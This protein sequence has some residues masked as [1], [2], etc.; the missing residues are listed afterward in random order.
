MELATA[1]VLTVAAGLVVF[2]VATAVVAG[3][4]LVRS[5]NRRIDD[6]AMACNQH[7]A[8]IDQN[9]NG[10]GA[11]MQMHHER[12]SLLERIAGLR[13]TDQVDQQLEDHPD[14]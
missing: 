14:A 6:Q 13:L 5:L 4:M 3:F 11:A 10:L 2:G 1:L 7:F 8:R 9:F 12:V